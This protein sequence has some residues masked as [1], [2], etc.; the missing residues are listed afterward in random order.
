M[1][2]GQHFQSPVAGNVETVFETPQTR[3]TM[4]LFDRFL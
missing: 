4:I 2:G 1:S 3:G